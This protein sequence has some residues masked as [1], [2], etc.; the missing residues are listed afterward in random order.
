MEKWVALNRI[1]G[2]CAR[3]IGYE[4]GGRRRDTLG[5]QDMAKKQIRETLEEI[6][7]ET[8]GRQWGKRNTR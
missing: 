7:Q 5:Q 8:I 4:G 3:E 6:L 1:F 2:V